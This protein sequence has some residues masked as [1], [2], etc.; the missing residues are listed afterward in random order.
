VI[1][2][3]IQSVSGYPGLF[4]VCVASGLVLPLPEDFALLYAGMRIAAGEFTW[5]PVI[6]IAIAGVLGRDVLSFM[7]GRV[8]GEW[9][10]SRSWGRRM[11]GGEAKLERARR[12]VETHGDAAIFMGRFMVG[13][14]SPVFVVSGAM[15]LSRRR[16]VLWDTI[17]LAIAVPVTVGLGY[18]FGQPIVDATYWLLQRTRIVVGIA[19]ALGALWW[20]GR[21]IAASDVS[22]SSGANE[23]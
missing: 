12:Y 19:V 7:I 10:L 16:F 4:I 21:R 14:R 18:A 1:R 8:A 2:D 5:F 11:F 3:L 15:G 9:L 22:E 20:I 6:P 17:G 13:F 23:D